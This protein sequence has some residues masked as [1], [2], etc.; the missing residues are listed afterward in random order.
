[1]YVEK[2]LTVEKVL[3]ETFKP[4]DGGAEVKTRKIYFY[5]KSVDKKTGLKHDELLSLKVIDD[6]LKIEDK[7]AYTF[8]LEAS[9]YQ[10]KIYFKVVGL[11]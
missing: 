11:K 4:R 5:E 2:A 8:I 10:S 1:M 9:Q 3:V 6:N 7:K